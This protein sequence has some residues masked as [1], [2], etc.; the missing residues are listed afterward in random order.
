[1]RLLDSLEF[2]QVGPAGEIK[3]GTLG[4]NTMTAQVASYA[5]MLSI[6]RTDIINDD[7]GV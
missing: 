6:T 4:D 5:K 2:D 3:H 1:M 7:L